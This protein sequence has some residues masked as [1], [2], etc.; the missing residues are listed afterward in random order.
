MATGGEEAV[1]PVETLRRIEL[2]AVEDHP[3][4]GGLL[5]AAAC[6]RVPLLG[7]SLEAPQV[8]LVG[9]GSAS[10][11][12]G[13]SSVEGESASLAGSSGVAADPSWPL[14][15]QQ[16]GAG[17]GGWAQRDRHRAALQAEHQEH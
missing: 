13:D 8:V 7:V 4:A 16:F 6:K 9:D 3:G 5:A 14:P 17:A 2:S 10:S 12:S 11:V 15:K 1:G